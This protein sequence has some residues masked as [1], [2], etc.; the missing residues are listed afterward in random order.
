M[1]SKS[2]SRINS[3]SLKRF[4]V[5]IVFVVV[6]NVT[7]CR[8][9]VD[10]WWPAWVSFATTKSDY[11]TQAHYGWVNSNE[12]CP[13]SGCQRSTNVTV[14]RKCFPHLSAGSFFSPIE[15]DFRAFHALDKNCQF[16]NFRRPST[17]EI[18][19][20]CS[21]L[22]PGGSEIFFCIFSPLKRL[23][24]LFSLHL[25]PAA[26]YE[27][28]SCTFCNIMLH[29]LWNVKNSRPTNLRGG[30]ECERSTH[31]WVENGEKLL[32]G[33][34]KKLRWLHVTRVSRW[35]GL[36]K[37]DVGRRGGGVRVDCVGISV[38]FEAGCV[39]LGLNGVECIEVGFE[40]IRYRLVLT[41]KCLHDV[42]SDFIRP[43]FSLKPQQLPIH[44]QTFPPKTSTHSFI[45][46][47]TFPLLIKFFCY[48]F[49]SKRHFSTI[50][51]ISFEATRQWWILWLWLAFLGPPTS[52]ALAEK[53]KHYNRQ[54]IDLRSYLLFLSFSRYLALHWTILN[55]FVRRYE[56]TE[57]N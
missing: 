52:T 33:V 40:V 35:M 12:K 4:N 36:H 20:R 17:L 21:K 30:G 23:C 43:N 1:S 28:V 18:K 15:L 41:T 22:F 24:W 47:K 39:V 7:S 10:R 56:E 25:S 37:I 14:I 16:I 8:S 57:R 32:I 34:D 19:S 55:S 9:S 49:H 2:S 26:V 51:I 42:P 11:S 48:V 6:H 45:L 3:Y 38:I 50:K 44:H 46:P 13:G 5:N 29:M 54:V 31:G 53:S 27:F